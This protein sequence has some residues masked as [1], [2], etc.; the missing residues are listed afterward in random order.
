V[1]RIAITQAAFE[2]IAATLPLGSVGY[3][4]EAKDWLSLA[5]S[6]EELVCAGL[7]SQ[8]SDQVVPRMNRYVGVWETGLAAGPHQKRTAASRLIVQ[9]LFAPSVPRMHQAGAG[10]MLVASRLAGPS[11]LEGHYADNNAQAQSGVEE[12]QERCPFSTV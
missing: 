6:P 7:S 12:V 10:A 9:S 3:E 11:A 5:T 2:A 8:R 1:V 4:N